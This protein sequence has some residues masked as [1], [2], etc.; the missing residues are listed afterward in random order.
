MT[1]TNQGNV[2]IKLSVTGTPDDASYE[3]DLWP[4]AWHTVKGETIRLERDPAR[5]TAQTARVRV[6]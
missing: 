1:F 6:E 4:G 5:S 3:V 2:V